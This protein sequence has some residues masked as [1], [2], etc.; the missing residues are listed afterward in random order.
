M[1]R[2]RFIFFIVLVLMLLS[3]SGKTLFAQDLPWTEHEIRQGE[4]LASIS[5]K[6]G[7]DPFS[8]KWANEIH[9]DEVPFELKILLIP[10]EESLL[11]ETMSEVR[12]RRNG[13]TTADLYYHEEVLPEPDHGP[14]SAEASQVANKVPTAEI[15]PFSLSWPVEG[16]LFSKFGPRRGR[17]HAGIDIS[18]PRGTPIHAAAAGTVV[19]AAW[20]GG[21]GRTILIDHHNGTMTRYSHCDTMICKA[22]DSV[23]AGQK[24]ATVGRTG[25]STGPH[26]HFEVIINGKHQD[27]E[28][29]LPAK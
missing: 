13:E 16:K 19:R 23:A 11:I 3:T 15:H 14:G 28:K 9:G 26:L 29:H 27:P 12:A 20:R 7:V 1:R 4:T 5:E 8:I 17:F 18:A 10:R 2:F 22:G 25:R 24:I 21:Y 6:Y